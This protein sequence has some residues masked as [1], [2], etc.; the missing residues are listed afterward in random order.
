MSRESNRNFYVP[1]GPRKKNAV[2]LFTEKHSLPPLEDMVRT[3]IFAV[4]LSV[5]AIVLSLITGFR[6]VEYEND[7]IFC[8]YSGWMWFGDEPTLGRLQSSDGKRATV[9]FGNIRYNDG[10]LYKG[11]I[12]NLLPNGQGTLELADGSV[13]VGTFSDGKYSGIGTYTGAD[14]SF[15]TGEYL[16]GKPNGQ[17]TLRYADGSVYAG[18]FENGE[19]SGQGEMTYS[20]GDSFAGEF[21]DDMREYGVYTWVNGESIEGKFTNNLPDKSEKMIYTDSAGDT[22]KA[23]YV[24]GSLTQKY[25]YTRPEKDDEPSDEDNTS[26]GNGTQTP[27]G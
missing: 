11:D 5:V 15:Y 17:G 24:D 6:T 18:G 27:A 4:I 8:R 25:A 23:F 13:Y 26:D 1:K 21:A 20:N 14:G 10:T 3:A 22:Y 9:F 7:E 12:K 2:E 16:N 19:K